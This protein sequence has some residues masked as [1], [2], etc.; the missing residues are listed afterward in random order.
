MAMCSKPYSTS[1]PCKWTLTVSKSHRQNGRNYSK[2]WTS[3]GPTFKQR[4]LHPELWRAVSLRG[5]DQHQ[6]CRVHG[7]QVVSRRF[8]KKQAMWWS[9]RGAHLLLQTRTKVLNEELRTR[10]GN[11]TQPSGLRSFQRLI[12]LQIRLPPEIY[13]R[14]LRT[15]TVW[16]WQRGAELPDGSGFQL[17]HAGFMQVH[18]LS[19]FRQCPFLIVVE[20]QNG[21]FAFRHTLDGFPQ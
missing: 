2:V 5:N 18:H 19:N 9:P 12:K 7:H 3:S 1:S 6:F 17:R 8:V 15:W 10:S 21:P 14:L 16:S 13:A 20:A 4:R 11:G